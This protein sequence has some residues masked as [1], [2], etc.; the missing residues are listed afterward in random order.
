MNTS[1]EALASAFVTLGWILTGTITYWLI[2]DADDCTNGHDDNVGTRRHNSLLHVDRCCPDCM[3]LA[4]NHHQRFARTIKNETHESC[5]AI[6]D[7]QG[8]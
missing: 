1:P 3:R 7:S 2:C 6:S 8:Y 4:R 5:Q